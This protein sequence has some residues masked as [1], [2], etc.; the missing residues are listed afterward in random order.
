MFACPVCGE[1]LEDFSDAFLAHMRARDDCREV[2]E[3]GSAS[4]A[5]EWS[6]R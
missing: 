3:A 4:T 1:P 5:A 6:K 2:Y